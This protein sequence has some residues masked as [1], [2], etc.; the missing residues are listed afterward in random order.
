M[1][2]G[3]D[4]GSERGHM[5]PE[6]MAEEQ[7][8]L[9]RVATL[10]ARGA[11]PTD[12]FAAV[13]A[14]VGRVL[15]VV[16][17]AYVGRYDTDR[18]V[19]FVGAWGRESSPGLLG[20]RV[21]IGGENAAT[22][23]FASKAPARVDRLTDAAAATKLAR[24]VGS[25]SSAGA[26]I[27][28]AGRL[29][30]V[31]TVSSSR[32]GGLPV[33]LEARLAGFTELVATA[34]ANAQAREELRTMANEQAALRRVATLVARAAPP[35]QV[36]T[37][38][39][40]EVGRL[41]SADVAFMCRYEPDGGP[42]VRVLGSWTSTGTA[43]TVAV[44]ERVEFEGENVTSKVFH[45]RRPVRIEGW[46]DDAGAALLRARAAGMRSGVGVPVSVQSR[47]WGVIIVGSGREDPLPPATE[48]RL[49]GFTELVAS[50][51]ANAEAREELRT[52][53]EEQAALRRVATLVAGGGTARPRSSP[54]PL[55]RS[56]VS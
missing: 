45:T 48:A 51:I 44:G 17:V 49:A 9:R 31:I 33:G 28:V 7:A 37:A 22:L 12:L 46:G 19:E 21:A 1:S 42:A 40:A 15:P 30:G 13:A 16:D 10:V 50:A 24:S 36:F 5:P 39:I 56:A 4:V 34:I 23:V 52:M 41:F 20:E 32:E 54:P 6:S 26:P 8:A 53:A 18:T 43:P 38:V 29:W 14:E 2:T 25:R 3:E 27:N 35:E 11:P 55:T 47:L